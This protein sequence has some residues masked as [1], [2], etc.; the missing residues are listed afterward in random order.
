M[1]MRMPIPISEEQSGYQEIKY[2]IMQRSLLPAYVSASRSESQER[3]EDLQ[4]ANNPK[5]REEIGLTNSLTHC[6]E[7]C[8]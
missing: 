1:V 5:E 2:K 8:D 6:S 7:E 3:Y 4:S